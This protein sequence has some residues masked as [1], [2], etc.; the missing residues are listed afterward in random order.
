MAKVEKFTFG[1]TFRFFPDSDGK[2]IH[3]VTIYTDGVVVEHTQAVGHYENEVNVDDGSYY[4]R[5]ERIEGN[6]RTTVER[7]KK[8]IVDV[9]PKEIWRGQ[10][11]ESFCQKLIAKYGRVIKAPSERGGV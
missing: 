4:L 11:S 5:G 9:P 2:E 10:I 7:K 3:I 8:Y 6:G 1:E